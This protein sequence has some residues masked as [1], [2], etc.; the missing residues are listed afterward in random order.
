MEQRNGRID[1][2]LQR[3]PQVRCH[4][5]VLSQRVEDRVL[6]VLVKKTKQIQEEMGSL[7]LVV[8]KNVTKLLNSGIRQ[9]EVK[10]LTEAIEL[11]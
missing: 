10:K 8:E 3:E 5:F 4:Y 6:D 2:K 9:S 1:R 7:S 11:V